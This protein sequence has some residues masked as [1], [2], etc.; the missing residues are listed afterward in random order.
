M[1]ETSPMVNLVAESAIY[2]NTIQNW[3]VVLTS[4]YEKII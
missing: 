3:S 4:R 1:D 2:K